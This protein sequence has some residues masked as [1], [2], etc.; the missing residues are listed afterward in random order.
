MLLCELCGR[1]FDVFTALL[2]P[3]ASGQLPT[4]LKNPVPDSGNS[5]A[6]SSP[7]STPR[8]ENQPSGGPKQ[9]HKPCDDDN[10]RIYPLIIESF[11]STILQQLIVIAANEIPSIPSAGEFDL[12][13]ENS[14]LVLPKEELLRPKIYNRFMLLG[15]GDYHISFL[16]DAERLKEDP[17]YVFAV[18][19]LLYYAFGSAVYRQNSVPP[20]S[21]VFLIPA[22][23]SYEDP[24]IDHLEILSADNF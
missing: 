4:P 24:S 8:E 22:S 16:V 10:I 21:Y 13:R 15:P 2:W 20:A 7:C 3:T 12:S 14:T 17:T 1:C 6:V 19:Q 9:K 23:S 5:S 11:N 18:T